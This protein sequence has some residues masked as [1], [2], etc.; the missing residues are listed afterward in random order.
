MVR[1]GIE[2]LLCCPLCEVQHDNV[3]NFNHHSKSIHKVV[4]FSFKAVEGDEG[5]ELAQTP[6]SLDE[7]PDFMDV[8]L[9]AQVS[10]QFDS[11]CF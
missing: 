8:D 11:I 9:P 3:K 10:L 5:A 2:H 7:E 6:P 1:D 4:K